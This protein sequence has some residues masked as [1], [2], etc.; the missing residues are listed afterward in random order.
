MKVK[1][2][3]IFFFVL[4]AGCESQHQ[5]NYVDPYVQ[6]MNNYN[7]MLFAWDFERRGEPPPPQ[8]PPMSY[9]G[10]RTGPN[11]GRESGNR[12]LQPNFGQSFMQGYMDGAV[13]AAQAR[14]IRLQEIQN[15]AYNKSLNIYYMILQRGSRKVN[16]PIWNKQSLSQAEEMNDIEVEATMKEMLSEG[17]IK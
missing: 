13:A 8:P 15:D 3:I 14:R 9:A 16:P 2:V 17:A 10:Q 11:I 5:T 7:K 6:S 4:I 1:I 12:Y